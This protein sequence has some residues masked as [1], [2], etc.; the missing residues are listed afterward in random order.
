MKTKTDLIR[1]MTMGLA[2]ALGALPALAEKPPHA[3]GGKPQWVDQK[4]E[5]KSRRS[6]DGGP[7]AVQSGGERA[8]LSVNVQIGGYFTAS[9]RRAV[10]DYYEPRFKAGQCPPGLAKKNNGCLPPGQ[11]KQWRK[12]SPLPPDTVAYPVPDGV[13][14]RLGLPP[15]GHKFVRVATDILLI[16]VGTGLVI[17]AIEDLGQL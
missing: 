2:L 5:D 12:G 3:G 4:G 11:A 8:G 15:E 9:Q 17:D 10:V 7:R 16:A 13:T 14:I 1:S 6:D